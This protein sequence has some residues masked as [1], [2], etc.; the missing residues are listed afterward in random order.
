[1][2][3]ESRATTDLTTRAYLSNTLAADGCDW[4]FKIGDNT[5]VPSD[6]T[7]ETVKKFTGSDGYFVGDSV[8]VRYQLT[9]RKKTLIC[10]WGS[11]SEKDE[12]DVLELKT[13]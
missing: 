1:M 4:H 3:P 2:E 9:G 11:K 7:L 12:M 8:T 13:R 6:G 5:Y 10:G